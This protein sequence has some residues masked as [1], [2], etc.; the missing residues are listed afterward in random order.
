MRIVWKGGLATI[1][2]GRTINLAC[3]SLNAPVD[4]AVSEIIGTDFQA[5]LE[6]LEAE[7]RALED[8]KRLEEARELWK[9]SPLDILRQSSDSREKETEIMKK[10]GNDGVVN[11]PSEP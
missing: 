8:Q 1:Q 9:S 3:G 7:K 10:K 11:R 6:K 4:E 2:E 5:T